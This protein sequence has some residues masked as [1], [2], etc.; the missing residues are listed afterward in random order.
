[1]PE[2]GDPQTDRHYDFRQAV[3]TWLQASKNADEKKCL[4]LETAAAK[5]LHKLWMGLEQ[6]RP[7]QFIS[8]IHD[9]PGLLSPHVGR[10]RGDLLYGFLMVT[11]WWVVATRYYARGRSVP[12]ATIVAAAR[13]LANIM[14]QRRLAPPRAL[15]Y[16]I[17]LHRR[18]GGGQK[19]CDLVVVRDRRRSTQEPI[20]YG[21]SENVFE[22]FC[23]IREHARLND[24]AGDEV[25]LL[26]QLELTELWG[27]MRGEARRD[28]DTRTALTG[29]R[30]T[31]KTCGFH[32]DQVVAGE[33]LKEG[34]RLVIPWRAIV[35]NDEDPPSQQ[36]TTET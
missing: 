3:E 25:P 18:S 33:T 9:V 26:R 20:T 12:D 36:G 21:I 11:S 4:A 13:C 1:M 34:L 17:L 32:K 35:V 27:T 15:G 23:A 22:L 10:M 7:D 14:E 30:A 8:T 6:L 29:L 31:L 2:T 24:D 5:S 16:Q 19:S 28:T